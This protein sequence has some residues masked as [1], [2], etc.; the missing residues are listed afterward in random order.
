VSGSTYKRCP[1]GGDCPDLGRRRHG[2]WFWCARISTTAGRQLIRRGG[3]EFERDAAAALAQVAALA[4]ID[5]DRTMQAKLGDLVVSATRRGGQLPSAAAVRLRLGAGLDPAAP[6]VTVA[7]HLESWLAVG[8]TVRGDSWKASVARSYRQ[9]CDVYLVPLLGHVALSR[10][11]AE[12]IAGMLDTITGWNAQVAAQ[13]AE[14]RARVDI[15]GDVR[16]RPRVVSNATVNRIYATLRSALSAAV[17]ERLIMWNPCAGV[18]PAAP[19]EHRHAVWSPEEVAVFLEHATA[20]GDRLALL[21]RLVLLLGLRRGEAVGL[22][23]DD[24]NLD[25]GKLH[26][27]HA[28]LSL[29]GKIVHDRPKTKTSVRD[30]S[31]DAES[32]RLLRVLR[33]GQLQERMHGGPAYADAGLVFCDELGALIHPDTVSARFRRA[34]AAAGVPVIRL[35]EGRHTS[36]TMALEAGVDL[37]HVSARLGHSSTGITS[38]VYQHVR[39]EVADADAEAMAA[40]LTRRIAP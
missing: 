23:W 37:K 12:H 6:D 15:P 20:T 22:T 5:A 33:L 10:L 9:H 19:G 35:H 8:R 17:R 30:V 24:L 21:W 38:D 1:H 13:R 11:R 25:A 36:A 3:F 7:E 14:G 34:A 27:G 32:V 2:S 16:A 28:V 39:R 26:I 4:G 31:L 40:M 29:G 18:R